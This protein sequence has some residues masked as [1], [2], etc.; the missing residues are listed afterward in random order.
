MLHIH[1][2]IARYCIPCFGMH[3]PFLIQL[4]RLMVVGS[5]LHSRH[6]SLS[7]VEVNS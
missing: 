5:Q 3:H 6:E 7:L 2:G 4:N 1:S